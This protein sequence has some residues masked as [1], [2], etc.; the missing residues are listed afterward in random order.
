M[1]KKENIY[2]VFGLI[3]SFIG[4]FA[5]FALPSDITFE[6]EA[7]DGVTQATAVNLIGVATNVVGALV[8]LYGLS[9][10]YFET[11][12][13]NRQSEAPNSLYSSSE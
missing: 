9:L 10:P 6:Y 13:E 3:L 2:I 5:A 12:K 7:S 1:I 4:I 8:L 11:R